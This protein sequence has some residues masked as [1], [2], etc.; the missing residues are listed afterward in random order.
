MPRFTHVHDLVAPEPPDVCELAAFPVAV[1]P[2]ALAALE[3]RIP[4][5]I[6]DSASYVRGVQLIRSLQMAILCG[7]MVDLI[8]S[9]DRIYRML[10]TALYGTDYSVISTDPLVVEPAIEAT[11]ALT[12]EHP[13]SLLGRAED[14][15]QLLQNG[16]NGTATTLYDRELGIRDLLELIKAA[17]EASDTLDPDM[18]AKLAEIALLLG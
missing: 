12:I 4:K 5:Y 2:Y 15:R 8:E 14:L 10:D 11:H 1:V 16:L 13:D 9:N 18:L 3:H 6:W 7:G 17:V